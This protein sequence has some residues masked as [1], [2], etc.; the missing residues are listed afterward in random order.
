V[1][2]AQRH[3]PQSSPHRERHQQNG[4]THA[5]RV[6]PLLAEDFKH[7]IARD[8]IAARLSKTVGRQF[9]Q[10]PMPNALIVQR[11]EGSRLTRNVWKIVRGLFAIERGRFL[12]E[13]KA[14]SIDI[15]GPFDQH[16]PN[17]IVP[18]INRP[19]IGHSLSCF[20]YTLADSSEIE[21]WEG[22]TFHMWLIEFMG[23]VSTLFGLSRS[24]VRLQPMHGVTS[25]STDSQARVLGKKADRRHKFTRCTRSYECARFAIGS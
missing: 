20:G 1:C 22:S 16:I 4:R 24:N 11:V 6:G 23:T 13:D 7:R 9:D 15:I 19:R 2:R 14:C 17:H 12:P 21:D 10:R 25:A 18:L 8:R 5:S 3:P